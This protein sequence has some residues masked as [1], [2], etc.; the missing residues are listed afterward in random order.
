M[1]V[2]SL[3][4]VNLE[5]GRSWWNYP[6]LEVWKFVNLFVF[7]LAAFLLHRRFGR[8]LSEGLRSRAERIKRELQKAR[9]E[10]DQADAK[11]AEV[12][13]RLERL[14]SEIAVIREQAKLEAEAERKRIRQ[15][16]ETEV[17]KLR[18]QAHRE[19]ESTA[20]AAMQELR[21]FAAEQSVS[22][23]ENALRR[24]IRPEDDARLIGLSVEQLRRSGR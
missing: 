16:T 20:K 13:F 12:E 6:G 10:K 21:R 19:I 5:V 9:E 4:V 18:H 15:A 23:A 2:L 8:P 24:D 7:V 22:M 14:G 11:L 17:K 3:V 1:Q